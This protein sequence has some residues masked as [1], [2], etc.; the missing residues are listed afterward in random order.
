MSEDIG[1][2]PS[3]TAFFESGGETAPESVESTSSETT[4][5]ESQEVQNE[6]ST[7]DAAVETK[8]PEQKQEKQEKTVPLAALHQARSEIK[9]MREKYAKMEQVFQR[10]AQMQE[11]AEQPKLPSLEENPV[12]YFEARNQ[13][14][15][16]TIHQLKETQ[17]QFEAR[18]AQEAQ[19]AQFRY[20][21][22]AVEAEFAKTNPDYPDAT[23]YLR[24]EIYQDALN[25]GATP[26][27]AEA[28]LLQQMRVMIVN[29]AQVG[30]NPAQ[31]VYHMAQARGF[32]TKQVEAPKQEQ[33]SPSE[34]IASINK[35]QAAA[36]SLS[37]T[38]GKGKAELTLEAM[39]EMDDDELA[40]H[41]GQIKK[42]M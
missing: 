34:K 38:G 2:T 14:L 18:Q 31:M 3:E 15:E 23:H 28:S 29:A 6:S 35:G 25:R 13:Q 17:Q 8:A 32:K 16:Q 19:E 42:L 41:W 21:V 40:K 20:A 39:A 27:E 22:Q 9:E 36:K 7:E 4:E 33:Q 24:S 26:Q 12:A 5:N 10:F 1:L 30:I 37:S 11:Q